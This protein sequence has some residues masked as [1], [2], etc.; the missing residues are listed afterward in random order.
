MVAD[1]G[2]VERGAWNGLPHDVWT[3]IM[4][5]F[6]VPLCNGIAF[7]P[8]SCAS[9]L[10]AFDIFS[11]SRRP[12]ERYRID[13]ELRRAFPATSIDRRC[14]SSVFE[15][16]ENVG[17]RMLAR[18]LEL[19]SVSNPG[20]HADE[21]LFFQGERLVLVADTVDHV[22]AVYALSSKEVARLLAV[23]ARIESYIRPEKLEA[24]TRLATYDE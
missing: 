17:E 24:R 14:T 5:R 2:V 11:E 19:W 4:R 10:D 3:G 6:L 16:D 1:F 23:D 18:P 20:T 7:N 21:I 22:I 15:F 9:E 8:V 13:I 12:K